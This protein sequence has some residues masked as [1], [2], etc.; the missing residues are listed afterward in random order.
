MGTG[1]AHPVDRVGVLTPKALL[2]DRLGPGEVGFITAAIKEIARRPGRR[3]DHRRPQA[4]R[5]AAAGLPARASRWCSAA[6]T[7][8]MPTT[9]AICATAW[10]SC[11]STTP[12]SSTSPR[13][14][15]PWASASAA[16]FWACCTSRSSR[17]AW[18]ASST[19]TSS[20]PRPR[21]STACTRPTARCSSCTTPPTIPDPTQID[22][23]EEPWIK[24][25][26]LVPDEFLGGDPAAVHREARRAGRADLCRQPG[27]GGL[28]PAA[29]RGGLRLLRPAEVDQPRLRQL[30]LPSRRL[31]R[32][33]SGQARRP[34][35][36]RPGRFACR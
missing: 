2:I 13:A 19:S 10:A 16:A 5:G 28:P 26:I 34:D 25:T 21:W 7:R 27:D 15:R 32:E 22:H 1:A 12:A 9:T 3:H 8:P 36:R 11:A 4:R 20:S 33:R 24:A 29:Q 35:Q 23:V 18:S 31:R 14:A 6:C 17:S 30:R